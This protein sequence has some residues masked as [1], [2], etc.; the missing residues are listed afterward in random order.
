MEARPLPPKGILQ[1]PDKWKLTHTRVYKCHRYVHTFR[2]LLRG[3]TT[4]QKPLAHDFHILSNFNDMLVRVIE[5][6]R[7]LSPGMLFDGMDIF[8]VEF[9]Q[10]LCERIKIIFFNRKEVSN[11]KKLNEFLKDYYRTFAK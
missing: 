10:F 9:F 2:N 7:P 1:Q 3:H 11:M 4:V 5:P 8:H 6:N